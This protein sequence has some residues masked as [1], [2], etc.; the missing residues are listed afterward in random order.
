MQD[1]TGWLGQQRRGDL[2]HELTEKLA[3]VTQAAVANDKPAKLTLTIEV[4]PAAK[5]HEMGTVLVTDQITTKLP[6]PTSGAAI[7][8]VDDDYGLQRSDPRQLRLV[9]DPSE[10]AREGEEESP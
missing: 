7:W 5:G 1:F 2:A 8:F 6:T 4:R 10:P 3:E 9:R